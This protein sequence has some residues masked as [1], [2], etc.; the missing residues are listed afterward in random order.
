[1]SSEQRKRGASWWNRRIFEGGDE[2]VMHL[3][4]CA[5]VVSVKAAMVKEATKRK[6]AFRASHLLKVKNYVEGKS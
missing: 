3:R 6:R 1:M 5:K 4:M 2:A